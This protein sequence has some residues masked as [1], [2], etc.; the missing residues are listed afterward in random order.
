M[1]LWNF[2]KLFFLYKHVFVFGDSVVHH[3]WGSL[4]V[5]ICSHHVVMSILL[6][7]VILQGWEVSGPT[8]QLMCHGFPNVAVWF[9]SWY[10]LFAIRK[11]GFGFPETGKQRKT[12]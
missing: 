6:L 10:Q 8:G 1:I 3:D 2:D 12:T 4:R 9:C 11:G 5:A 7:P